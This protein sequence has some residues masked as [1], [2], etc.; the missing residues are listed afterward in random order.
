MRNYTVQFVRSARKELERLDDAM[1]ERVFRRVEA[2][3]LE[4]RPSGCR[5]LRGATDLW[6]IRIGSYRV[7]YQVDD[8]AGVVEIRAVGDRKDVYG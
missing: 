1:L 2:L 7:I 5:K 4:P 8:R 6:R 3:A